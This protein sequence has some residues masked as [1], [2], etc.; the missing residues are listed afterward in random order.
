M[1]LELLRFRNLSFVLVRIVVVVVLNSVLVMI[2]V[3]FGRILWNMI[4][5]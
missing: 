1:M 3:M 5:V 2:D 4:C